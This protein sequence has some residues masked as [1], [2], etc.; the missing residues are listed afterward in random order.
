MPLIQ[1]GEQL[2]GYKSIGHLCAEVINDQQ[3]AVIQIL[4]ESGESFFCPA[5][6]GLTG[7]SFKQP[8]STDIDHGMA[9]LQ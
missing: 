8:G 5:V 9:G 6:E 7:K 4:V 1:T 2:G 3:I